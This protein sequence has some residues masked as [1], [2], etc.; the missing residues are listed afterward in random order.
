MP[1]NDQRGNE[2]SHNVGK[3]YFHQVPLFR[4]QHTCDSYVENYYGHEKEM[5]GHTIREKT[6]NKTKCGLT[7][8]LRKL[9]IN[10]TTKKN[11]NRKCQ[12]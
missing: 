3:K 9:I 12:E 7:H 10:Q 11:R 4:S 2:A 5:G 1:H 8:F 6:L